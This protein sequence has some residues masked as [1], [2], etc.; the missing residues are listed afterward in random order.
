MEKNINISK[1]AYD[2]NKVRLPKGKYKYVYPWQ[3]KDGTIVYQS[4]ISKY[5][6]SKYFSNEK[7]AAIGVDKYLIEKGLKPINI[8]KSI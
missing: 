7:D 5:K 3:K 6:W 8:L 4:Y 2:R 1:D